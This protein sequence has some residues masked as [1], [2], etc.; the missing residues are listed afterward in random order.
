MQIIVEKITP[1]QARQY[2]DSNRENRTIRKARVESYAEQM[3]RGQWQITG[4]P[5]RFDPQGRLLDGQHRLLALIASGLKHL[6]MVVIRDVPTESFKVLDSG[7]GRSYGDALGSD[8]HGAVQVAAACR[9]LYCVEL[10]GDPRNNRDMAVITRTDAADYFRIHEPVMVTAV[11]RAD[12]VYRHFAGGN[13]TALCGL[14]VLGWQADDALMNEFL[15]SLVTGAN[16]GLGDP[17]LALRNW[18]SNDR[19]LRNAGTHLALYIKA[20]ND[21]LNGNER[22]L[23]VIR[24]DEDFPVFLTAKA[25]ALGR[26]AARR[27]ARTAK[28][29][30]LG[31]AAARRTARN[32]AR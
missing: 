27:T 24:P 12:A 3:K 29:D 14:I 23:M 28:A 7:L 16:L 6:E 25:D 13:K 1:S 31:R 32:A 11:K 15:E 17:R 5:V 2:L 18:L 8:V 4:D 20:W 19:T 22:N 26:A 10:G 9:L 30:A 21:W